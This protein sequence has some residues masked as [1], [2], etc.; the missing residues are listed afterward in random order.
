MIVNTFVFVISVF[1]GFFKVTYFNR[2]SYYANMGFS[3]I[4][5]NKRK[6]YRYVAL[7]FIISALCAFAF[8][9]NEPLIKIHFK[10]S[11][12]VYKQYE[13]KTE[14]PQKEYEF[15]GDVD[16][17]DLEDTLGNYKDYFVLQI[18][19]QIVKIA[20]IVILLFYVIYFLIRPFFTSGWKEFWKDHKLYIYFRKLLQEIKDFFSILFGKDAETFA[21]VESNS[22]KN[23][24]NNLIKKS[25]KSKEKKAEL[26]RLTKQF[27]NLIDWGTKRDIKYKVNF[28]PAE[29]T[30]LI[31]EYFNKNADKDCGDSAYKVGLLFEKALYDKELLSSEEEND[32]YESI[33]SIISNGDK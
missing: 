25:K 6:Y 15:T 8:S 10:E 5:K 18:I 9:R 20:A 13:Y 28:A 16:T 22:F 24:I 30:A 11:A 4:I 19:F 33:K 21:T 7:V 3:E 23:S 31:N 2:E 29:Y 17:P 14:V 12:P 1:F 26:D 27:I 32:Y